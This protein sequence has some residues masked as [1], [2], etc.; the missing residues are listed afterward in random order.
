MDGRY[1]GKREASLL[2]FSF[3][4]LSPL[5]N[6]FQISPHGFIHRVTIIITRACLFLKKEE[7]TE[8]LE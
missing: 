5:C 1:H 4:H 3:D 8:E 6:Q 7:R 2:S